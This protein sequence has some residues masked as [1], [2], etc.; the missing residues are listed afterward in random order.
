M[1][2]AGKKL[3]HCLMW[4]FSSVSELSDSLSESGMWHCYIIKKQ[5]NIKGP[6]V[7]RSLRNFR[8]YPYDTEILH[9]LWMR[10]Y[11]P[12]QTSCTITNSNPPLRH[13]PSKKLSQRA[14]NCKSGNKTLKPLNSP[15]LSTY[16]ITA[17][18]VFGFLF[19]LN[20]PEPHKHTHTHTRLILS[21]E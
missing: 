9:I 15:L 14:A 8:F 3:S 21:A 16:L 18:T 5:T 12:L 20:L 11:I 7:C 10:N 2:S 1:R 13:F 4:L 6:K 17:A 19:T